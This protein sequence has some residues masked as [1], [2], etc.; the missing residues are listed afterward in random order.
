MIF[1]DTLRLDA[2]GVRM[3]DGHGALITSWT[4]LAPWPRVARPGYPPALPKVSVSLTDD[5]G[6]R[7]SQDDVR[8]SCRS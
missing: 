6:Y 8:P 3:E 7:W 2:A 5:D 4:A 1:G